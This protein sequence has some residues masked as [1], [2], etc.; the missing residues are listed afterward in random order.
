MKNY[1]IIALSIFFVFIGFSIACLPQILLPVCLGGLLLVLLLSKYEVVNYFLICYPFLDFF[2]RSY[3]SAFASIWDELLF[4]GMIFI[5]GYKYIVYR[6][7]DGFKQTPLDLP[8]FIFIWS[9]V[10]VFILNSPDYSISFDGL[11]ANIQYVL[12]YFVALQLLKDESSC[13]NLC[14]IFVIVVG[15]MGLHGIYQYIIGVEIPSGWTDM[16]EAG[17]R[18]RVFSILTSPNI[19]GSLMTLALPIC[20]SFISTSLKLK[21]KLLFSFLTLCML[22]TLVFTY[23]RGAWIGFIGAIFIYVFLKDKKMIVPV[24][25]GAILV[26]ICVPSVADRITYMLSP[27]YIESSLRG[28]RLVRWLTG[29]E[30]LQS[31]P[32]LGV[33]LGHFGGAVAMNNGLSLLVG[34]D[35][36]NTFY[37]DNYYLKTA[38]E[39]GLFG[40]I[41]FLMLMYQVFI[42]SVRSIKITRKS[43]DYNL[44][45]GILAGLF[46]VMVHNFVENVFEVPM[47]TSCFWVLVA[48][49]M[50]FWYVSFTRENSLNI[51]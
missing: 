21:Q 14:V 17:V 38:V 16:K 34:I 5:W 45:I 27:E 44:Q 41:I 28:G 40:L 32:I 47:M 36:I 29:I 37:M 33:G 25:I 46:G 20:I 15:L 50:N 42:N 11:R 22:G 31:Y 43:K 1:K 35:K 24:I 2:F 49:I 26:F 18:T 3:L 13:R 10:V 8:I 30:I 7:E 48:V 19:L 39:S 51:N 12:W 6:K 23:S 4:I 9:M